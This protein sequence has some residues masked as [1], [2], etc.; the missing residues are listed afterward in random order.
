MADD[1]DAAR[2]GD[3]LAEFAAFDIAAL[4]HSEID[5][6]RAWPH[7]LDH[8]ARDQHRRLAAGYERR[9]DDDVDL[10]ERFGDVLALTPREILA[11]LL[12]IAA[13]RLHRLHRFEIDD[14][15]AGTQALH[16]LL[17]GKPHVRRR[18]DATQAPRCSDRLQSRD[19]SAHDED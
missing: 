2:C 18:D 4:L 11:H 15:K 8:V 5:D 7:D 1:G 3:G 9:A 17:S 16:L 13:R 10:L 19:T 14:E 12:G 6:D